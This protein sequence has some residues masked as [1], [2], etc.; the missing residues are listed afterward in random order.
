[1][2]K[3]FRREFGWHRRIAYL[4]GY[5]LIRLKK[6]KHLSAE[7][8]LRRLIETL[9]IDAILDVGANT[10]QFASLVR[11]LGYR[12]YIFSFEPIPELYLSLCDKSRS[13]DNWFV[14][15]VALGSFD[16]RK[17]LNL[18][19]DSAFSSFYDPSAFALD[20]WELAK[21]ESRVEVDVKRLDSFY[22]EVLEDFDLNRFFLKM[23]TQG[24]DLEVFNGAAGILP[25][26]S[27]LQSELQVIPA[28][29]QVAGYLAVLDCYNQAG[30][31]ITGLYP[32]ARDNESMAIIEF[33][34]FM[35]NAHHSE[36]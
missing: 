12:G 10:G 29:D 13:D 16:E 7:H 8:H 24:H 30:F 31:S 27:G 3:V 25:K 18:T 32:I 14:Y 22:A 4:F 36:G 9:E 28:Y 26:L 11:S 34:C 15:P 5:D 20:R 35:R 17:N 19:E 33:D 6:L 23:D 1:M 21:I 2:I